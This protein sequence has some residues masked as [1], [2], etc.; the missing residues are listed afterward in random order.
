MKEM[1]ISPFFIIEKNVDVT[2]LLI[3]I[4]AFIFRIEKE[5]TGFSLWNAWY[6]H[7]QPL[8]PN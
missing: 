8:F 5:R 6:I 7:I 4:D 2:V 1:S 3:V